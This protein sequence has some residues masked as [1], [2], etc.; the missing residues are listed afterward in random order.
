MAGLLASAAPAQQAETLGD[1][2]QG[3]SVLS[4]ELERLRAELNTTGLPGTA[5]TGSTLDRLNTIESELMRLTAKAEDL[6]FRIGRVVSDGTN[7]IGDL[8]FRICEL[9]P[10]CEIGAL[11]QTRPLG[12]DAPA[13]AA[14]APILP[15][16]PDTPQLAVGE[17]SDYR[18]AQEALANGDF[19]GAAD[20]FATFRQT[21]PGSPLE[22]QSLLSEGEA[23]AGMGDTR[24]AARLY[25]S[26]YSGYPDHPLAPE[27]LA[28]LGI[29]LGVLGKVA[30]ACVT[31]AEVPG[32]YPGSAAVAA[33][34]EAMTGLACP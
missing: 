17:E 27:A 22:P 6:E 24:E 2:R 14:P 21:Y 16:T 25:L 34:Q 5:V 3:L 12:G 4:V 18:R 9:E 20:Q 11:G 15:V 19:R 7:R 1:L 30:E 23:H 13:A 29:A 28:R 32:R 31:L 33:A 8:E 10:G 26:L